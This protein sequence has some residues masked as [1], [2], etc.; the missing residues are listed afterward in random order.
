V[1]ASLTRLREWKIHFDFIHSRYLCPINDESASFA[2]LLMDY[3]QHA[4]MA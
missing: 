3:A 2:G 4:D 1:A